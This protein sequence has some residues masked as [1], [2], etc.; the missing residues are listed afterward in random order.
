MTL[1]HKRLG[2]MYLWSIIAMMFLGGAFVMLIRAEL[3]SPGED[4]VSADTFNQLFTLHGSIM[5]FLVIIPSIPAALGNF[6]LPLMLGAKD[7]AF[8]KL[9]R[10]S[11][12]LYVMGAIFF[13]ASMLATGLDTGW[14]FYAPYSTSESPAHRAILFAVFGAFVLGFSSIFTGLN[15]LVTIHKMRPPGMTWFKMPLFLWAIYATSIIQ[16]LATPVIGITLLLVAV[17]RMLEIGIFNPALGGDPVLFQHMFWF[18]SHPAVYIMLLPAMGVM[19]ELIS[20]YSRKSIFGYRYIALSSVAI[21]VVSFVVWGHHMY[22]SGQSVLVSVLFS[23]ITFFVAVPSAVKVFN[24]IATLYKGSI[25]LTSSMI[26]GLAI[27]WLFGIGGL[28]GLWLAALETDIHLHDTYFVVSHFHFV[29]VGSA[30]MAFLGGIH[31]WWPKFY[32]T[33]LN[34]KVSLWGASLLFL[35]F[36][37]TFLP[38]FIAG[39]QGMPRRYFDYAE[40]FEGYNQI[41]TVGA[42]LMG[43]SMLLIVT[44]F[45]RS[46]RSGKPAPANPWG[47]VTLEWN[48]A[49]IPDPHNFDDAPVVGDPYDL[50]IFKWDEAEGGYVPTRPVPGLPYIAL[51]NADSTESQH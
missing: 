33:M 42:F 13:V 37:L 18:Y 6:V 27:I 41:S 28:T 39:T 36:N 23:A 43:F 35:G 48:T 2:L 46:I 4:F 50:S 31:H 22:V 11:Y 49:P 3:F 12:H 44:N 47:A 20:T 29:M 34:E 5:V 7:V 17:E 21:A 15:F 32:G 25:R 10:M 8:P 19:S 30:I 24:W 26:Y 45:L 40:R 51:P 9:N 1:D 38:Q 16:I 14:T